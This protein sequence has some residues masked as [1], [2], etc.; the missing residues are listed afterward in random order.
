M[1]PTIPA[2]DD[3]VIVLDAVIVVNAPVLAV[4]FPIGPGVAKRAVK[5][6][7]LT[8]PDAESVVNAPVL[9]VVAPTGVPLIEPPL[10]VALPVETLFNVA[11]PVVLNVV[12]A[13]VFGVVEPIAAGAANVAPPSCAAF[14]AV[15][16]EKPVPFA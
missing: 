7:P 14:I 4:V 5:P 2:V 1:V 3:G 12:N 6:A 16:H 10:T 11:N 15:L 13:P 8:V 9:A